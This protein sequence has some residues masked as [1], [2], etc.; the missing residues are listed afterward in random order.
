[1]SDHSCRVLVTVLAHNEERRIAACLDSLP[2]G[3]EGLRIAVVVNGSTDATAGIVRGYRDRG[4]ELVEYAEG[5][6]AR[7]WNRFILDAAP[8]A[9]SYVFVDGD[10]ELVPGSVAALEACLARNPGANAASAPPMNGRNAAHYRRLMAKEAG[11]FGDCYALSG[12]FVARLRDSG[13]RLPDD[14]VGDD[15]LIAALAH[16]DLGGDADWQAERVVGCLEAGFYCLPNPLTSLG[17]RQQ[18]KRMTNYALR[19]FQNRMITAIMRSSGPQGLPQVLA[20]IYPAWLDRLAPRL[21]P[22]WYWFDRR[23]LARMRAAVADLP[24]SA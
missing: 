2:L 16:T 1:M 23:A 12:N 21:N 14:L 11:L 8:Q 19:R 7:S 22:L 20:E 5:G 24:A 18:A 13:I 6:K 15:G 3:E 10:A 9:A 4:V 17:L